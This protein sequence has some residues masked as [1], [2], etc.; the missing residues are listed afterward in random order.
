MPSATIRLWKGLCTTRTNNEGVWLT[1]ISVGALVAIGTLDPYSIKLIAK[2]LALWI[3]VLGLQQ[4]TLHAGVLSL[5]HGAFVAAGG[6]VAGILAL[7]GQHSVWLA[8]LAVA[9]TSCALGLI[10]GAAV[11]RTQG[12]YQLMATLAIAQMMFYGFQSLRSLGGDEGFAIS[13]RPE[14]VGELSLESDRALAIGI[15][16]IALVCVFAIGRLRRSELGALMQ[17]GRDDARRL[18]SLG[19]SPYR[20]NL[21][22][23]ALSALLAGI[24]GAMLAHIARFTSPQMGHWLFSGELVVLMLLGGATTRIGPLAACAALVMIQ[25]LLS[26]YTDHWLLVLGVVALGRVLWPS[27]DEGQP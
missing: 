19:F 12:L 14:I 1:L 8:L 13:L 15:L 7:N 22:A 4:L 24:G 18:S 11:L 2:V 9:I 21:T 3:I 23:F 27:S 20:V 26:Q 25:E 17:A 10:V 5:G 6:Y 16:V